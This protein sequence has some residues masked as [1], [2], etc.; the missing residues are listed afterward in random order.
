MSGPDYHGWT[1][2][3]KQLGGTDPLQLG[4]FTYVMF[5]ATEPLEEHFLPL[6]SDA[7]FEVDDDL[8]GTSLVAATA[9]VATPSSSGLVEVDIHYFT[10][11]L[12]GGGGS[13][14]ITDLTIDAGE[15]STRTASTPPVYAG[16]TVEA[17]NAIVI[18]VVD[19]GTDTLGLSVN[20]TFA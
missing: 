12:G 17:G 14:F 10:P 9:T 8:H 20:M 13:L 5:G 16:T 4:K 6:D 7:F 19:A 11:D 3:P 2:R 1:H 18:Q 15:Y